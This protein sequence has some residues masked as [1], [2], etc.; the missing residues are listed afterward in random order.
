MAHAQNPRVCTC[1]RRRD[2]LRSRRKRAPAAMILT[3]TARERRR[4]SRLE[5]QAGLANYSFADK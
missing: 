4:S 2:L 5:G 3:R 1:R